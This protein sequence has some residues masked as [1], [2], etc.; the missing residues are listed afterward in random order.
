MTCRRLAACAWFCCML[1]AASANAQPGDRHLDMKA[2]V[3]N[4]LFPLDVAPKLYFQRMVLRF[5]D[6]DTQLVVVVYPDKDKY[7]VRKCEITSYALQGMGKGELSQFISKMVAENPNLQEQEIA[8]KLKVET[9]R[10]SVALESFN[11]ALDELKAIRIS[12]VL[13]DRVA[14]DEY[15]EYEFW[16]DNWQESVH[17]A[18]TG[19]FGDDPQDQL[20]RWMTKFR[21][22]VPNLLKAGLGTKV[23]KPESR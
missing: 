15:S 9:T 11:R 10:S 13:A 16:Y 18:I 17:Y 19:P 20:G 5:S 3:L 23:I 22:N 8:A 14:M 1:F 7:W 6:S 2:R 12:P 21:D 4:I